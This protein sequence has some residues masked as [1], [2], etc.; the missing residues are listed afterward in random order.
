M[1]G[2]IIIISIFLG[3]N[4][5]QN[6][7]RFWGNPNPNVGGFQFGGNM[8]GPGGAPPNQPRFAFINNGPGPGGRVVYRFNNGPGLAHGGPIN[9]GQPGGPVIMDLV[10][11][12]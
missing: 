11:D 12:L 8:N 7:P 2:R 5:N 4:P 10:W 3:N 1:D 9:N 6:P